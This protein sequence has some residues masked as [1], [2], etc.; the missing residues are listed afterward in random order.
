MAMLLRHLQTCDDAIKFVESL[1][2]NYDAFTEVPAAELV[3]FTQLSSVLV[4]C[5]PEQ[6]KFFESDELNEFLS[7]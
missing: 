7:E 3:R 6:A 1:L 4:T 5:T 2:A